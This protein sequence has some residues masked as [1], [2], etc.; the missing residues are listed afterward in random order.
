VRLN[1]QRVT[2]NTSDPPLLPGRG[3]TVQTYRHRP[4]GRMELT[5]IPEP[6][7]RAGDLMTTWWGS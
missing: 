7:L 6:V 2:S 5:S 4:S 3:E 1:S